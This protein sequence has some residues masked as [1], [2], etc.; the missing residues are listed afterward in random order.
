VNGA[1]GILTERCFLFLVEYRQMEFGGTIQPENR[2]ISLSTFACRRSMQH[3]AAMFYTTGHGGKVF[4]T[5]D[6]R[7][8]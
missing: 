8:A 4:M 3:F 7:Y 2:R 1:A 5:T 6:R